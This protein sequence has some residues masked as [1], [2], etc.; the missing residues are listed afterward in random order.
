MVL[1]RMKPR[2]RATNML[3]ERRTVM[4]WSNMEDPVW[5]EPAPGPSIHCN[6]SYMYTLSVKWISFYVL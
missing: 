4:I 6:T 1:S 2:R 3:V 5:M